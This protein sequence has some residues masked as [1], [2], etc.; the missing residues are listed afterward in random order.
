MLILFFYLSSLLAPFGCSA[1]TSWL[2]MADAS[3]CFY[4]REDLGGKRFVRHEGKPVCVRCHTKFCANTCAECHRPIP[5]ESKVDGATSSSCRFW[6]PSCD[7]PP[8]SLR[9][10]GA[11][12]QGPLLAWGVF[13]VRK[14]L[15]TL[16][17]RALQ[18]Q[19]WPHHVREVLLPRG[20]PALPRLLQT[21][22]GR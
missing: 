7:L 6:P 3:H 16:G 18:H 5:V 22:T 21:D 14:V 19:G 17:Q 2:T 12:P 9:P 20:C 4:C 15:Q 10:S 11:E 1:P 13:P 8:L